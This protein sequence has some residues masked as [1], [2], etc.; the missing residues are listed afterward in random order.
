MLGVSPIQNWFEVIKPVYFAQFL[1]V[2]NV[3]KFRVKVKVRFGFYFGLALGL[4][5][6]RKNG[7]AR[8]TPHP[9]TTPT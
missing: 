4:V 3:A 6:S 9:R 7:P 2:N 8:N 5:L 1:H